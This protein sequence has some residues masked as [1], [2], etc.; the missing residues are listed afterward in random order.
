MFHVITY[1]SDLDCVT[2][3]VEEAFV[4]TDNEVQ[5]I[6]ARNEAA[7]FSTMVNDFSDE[8]HDMDYDA[9]EVFDDADEDSLH[10]VCT[11]DQDLS[12]VPF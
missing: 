4:D 12:A 8:S 11:D 1:F 6:I 7:G 5:A 10:W 3:Q 9:S 2:E